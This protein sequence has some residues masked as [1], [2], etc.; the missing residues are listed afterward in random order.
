MIKKL[1]LH[2]H[3]VTQTADDEHMSQE[4][5]VTICADASGIIVVGQ[6]DQEIIL[7]RATIKDL[8]KALQM[9]RN[10][11]ESKK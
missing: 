3:V 1:F 4:P 10:L 8:N 5:P 11:V 2:P 6:G 9:V 7:N